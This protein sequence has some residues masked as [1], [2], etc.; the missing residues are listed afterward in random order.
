M[1]AKRERERERERDT[2]SH[3]RDRA[4]LHPPSKRPKVGTAIQALRTAFTAGEKLSKLLHNTHTHA[5]IHTHTHTLGNMIQQHQTLFV[6]VTI[7][8][9][10]SFKA[11][12]MYQSV[13][14]YV[15]TP[16]SFSLSAR[17]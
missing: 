16:H 13:H 17:S 8:M 4:R 5:H 1:C 3:R 6:L 12:L 14:V 7:S 15:I 2:D 11:T 9:H 10:I